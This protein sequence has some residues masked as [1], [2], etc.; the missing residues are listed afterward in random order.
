M[1][2]FVLTANYE[3]RVSR[4]STSVTTLMRHQCQTRLFDQCTESVKFWYGSGP[5]LDPPLFVSD[6]QDAKKKFPKFFSFLLF[7]G[8]FTSYFNR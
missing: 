6:L 8:T 7:E 5:D 2:I 4:K 1:H 3:L